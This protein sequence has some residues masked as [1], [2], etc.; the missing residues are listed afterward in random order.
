MTLMGHRK[1]VVS[2]LYNT[3]EHTTFIRLY[4]IKR[5]KNLQNEKITT[6]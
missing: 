1:I 5:T 2:L 6:S 3:Q 4:L